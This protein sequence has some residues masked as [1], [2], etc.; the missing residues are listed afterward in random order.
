MTNT[1]DLPETERNQ[2]GAAWLEAGLGEHASVAAFARFVLH[3]VTLGAPSGLVR[4]AI[5]AMDDEVEHARL[6]FGIAKI[7][8][9]RA[10]GPGP[11]DLS[12]VFDQPD[13]P[14]SILEAAIL[15]G[16]IAETISARC[17]QAALRL[18]ADPVIHGPLSR[19][20]ADE[21]RHA[22]LSWHFVTWMLEKYPELKTDAA[23][24]FENALANPETESGPGNNDCEALERFGHLRAS[25]RARVAADVV[26]HEIKPRKEALMQR[27]FAGS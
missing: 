6:C 21:S 1:A 2:V 15:E 16:C 19:I 10:A 8:T 11:M 20:A 7:F 5:R 9:G 26:Q 23:G 24:F 3:L 22:D 14:P 13:D 12:G 27:F 4:E 17:A 18:V 25:S